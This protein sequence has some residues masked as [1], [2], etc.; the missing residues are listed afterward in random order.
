ML[1]VAENRCIFVSGSA[2]ASQ[3]T[4]RGVKVSY[5][6][7]SKLRSVYPIVNSYLNNLLTEALILPICRFRMKRINKPNSKSGTML[8]KGEALVI[9]SISISLIAS[10]AFVVIVSPW[11]GLL[12]VPLTLALVFSLKSKRQNE[13]NRE[14]RELISKSLQP[15]M[16]WKGESELKATLKRVFQAIELSYVLIPGTTKGGVNK[17]ESVQKVIEAIQNSFSP[18]AMR[19]TLYDNSSSL[20]ARRYLVGY[21]QILNSDEEA[22]VDPLHIRSCALSFGGRTFGSLDLEF[23]DARKMPSDFELQF[24]LVSSYCSIL[25]MNDEFSKEL[26]R[27]RCLSDETLRTK[28][29]FL[30][31]LSHEIRGPLGVILNSVELISD[32]LCGEVTEMQKDTL[33]MVRKSSAHLMDL[34]NDVLDYAKVESGSVETKAIGNS[35]QDLLSDMAAIVRSQAIKKNQ[36]LIVERAQDRLGL[37]C[38]KRHLRQILI[39][40]LTNAIKYTPDG[41][42]ISLTGEVVE[43]G[44]VRVSVKDTGVGIPEDQFSKVLA[45]FERVDDEYSKKQNGTGLGMALTKKLVEANGGLLDFSSEVGVG[46]TFWVDFPMMMVDHV[47]TEDHD[48]SAVVVG[49]SEEILLLEPDPDQRIMFSKSLEQ[50]GFNVTMVASPSEALS[51]CRKKVFAAMI[52]ETDLPDI[53]AED[54]IQ[55]IRSLPSCSKLPIIVMSG[56]AFTFDVERFLKLGVDRCLS[57]PFTLSELAATL[58]RIL[59]EVVIIEE[60]SDSWPQLH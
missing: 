17:N 37:I 25:L 19:I 26:I 48:G 38:D 29:G 1:L 7:N 18:R 16:K 55:S 24:E 13:I 9:A 36:K 10:L 34:V 20:S 39:N 5:K 46:S 42:K 43:D 14:L 15:F 30:A 41:G 60:S 58:R 12:S 45:P 59:D 28:T 8:D 3:Y 21:P 56:K 35:V 51:A 49:K 4:E 40:L 57:K 54:F 31:T 33:K 27:L 11:C 53:D 32:G 23:S 22:P 47:A 52:V 44:V 6:R 50:R 2:N